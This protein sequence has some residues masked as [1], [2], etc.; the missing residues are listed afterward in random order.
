ME[1]SRAVRHEVTAE[2]TGSRHSELS[3]RH[4]EWGVECPATDIDCI[5][6]I[7]R[8]K[9]AAIIEYK[10]SNADL[11]QSL[12][13]WRALWILAD[14]AKLPF[15]VVVWDN[16]GGRWTF[17]IARANETGIR[18]IREHLPFAGDAP[19]LNERDFVRFLHLVRGRDPS[20]V[21][22]LPAFRPR[23]SR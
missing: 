1:A 16:G 20:C 4:R 21:D 14:K 15:W 10:R 12:Q 17:R 7:A 9:P 5:V 8:G 6:E 11:E 19:L 2:R 23:L 3:A 13:S 22:S 18:L